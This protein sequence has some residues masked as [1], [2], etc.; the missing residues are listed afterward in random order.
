MAVDQLENIDIHQFL[1]IYQMNGFTRNLSENSD[2]WSHFTKLK[3]M[4]PQARLLKYLLITELG[5]GAVQAMSADGSGPFPKARRSKPVE[6]E[7]RYKEWAWT[8]DVPRVLENKTGSEL[9]QYAKPLAT[10]LDN[11][12]VA[13][14]RLK[15]IELQ[16]DGTGVQGVVAATPTIVDNGYTDVPSSE[17][18]DQIKVVIKSD[19]DNAGRSWIRW[20]QEGDLFKIHAED[21][22]ALFAAGGSATDY[23][24]VVDVVESE[25]A[26]IFDVFD[27]DDAPVNPTG[28]NTLA[29]GAVIRR[30][31]VS[32]SDISDLSGVEYSKVSEVMVGL[33]S[34]I[35]ADGRLVHGLNRSGALKG[36]ERDLGGVAIDSKHFQQILS[37]LKVNA[38]KGRY[39]YPSA[40]MSDLTYDALVEARETD[41]RFHSIEDSD[42]GVKGIGYVHGKD[43][44]EFMP[45]EFVHGQRIWILPEGKDALCYVGKDPQQVKPNGNDSFHLT[46]SSGGSGYGRD[47]Q[48]FFE[49]TGVL[50]A[51]HPAACG[52]LKNFTASSF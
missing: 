3:E 42:R 25:S 17:V 44:V 52:V 23:Y 5:Y 35:A 12:Q 18:Y 13:F 1:K 11:K 4:D 48:T 7:A 46:L 45:D 9:M 24:K 43:R 2:M 47:M 31:G 34:L 50:L 6:A 8:V 28:A 39:K 29:A 19:S 14:A 33:E 36:T 15:C 22:T 20:F 10:E 51:K 40:F 30:I 37:R 38:G 41:R 27:E 32:K 49:Q 21:G 16:G 26:V